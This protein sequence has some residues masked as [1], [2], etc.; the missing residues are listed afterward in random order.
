MYLVHFHG[1]GRNLLP[2]GSTQDDEEEEHNS[3]DDG[4]HGG[5]Q[6]NLLMLDLENS[7]PFVPSF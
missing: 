2:I 1:L 5:G 7:R 3:S 6:R 4:V